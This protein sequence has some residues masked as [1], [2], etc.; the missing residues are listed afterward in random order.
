[1]R[2]IRTKRDV[3]DG[4][5][6]LAACDARLRPV[7]EAAGEP[8][9]R[10]RPPGFAGLARI[11]VAQQVSVASAT[12]VWGRFETHF[13]GIGMDQVARASDDDLRV[14]GLSAP[15]IRT[16]RAIAVACRAGLD[17]E[18]LD[19]LPQAEALAKL[20]AVKG[21]GPWSAEI[22][23]M[24]CLGHADI[25]PAGDLAL[26]NAVSDALRRSDLIE[27]GELREIAMAWSPWR[28]VAARLFWAYFSAM[29]AT[30]GVPA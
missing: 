29:R 18:A 16:L 7:I 25:F 4:L 3:A 19:S 10:R 23:L 2:I 26:R 13:P 5:A 11:V 21:I 20:T 22:Y 17:L 9:L 8:A 6:Y 12:A 27:Q 15:K 28:S 1:M 24:F 14:V 30:E